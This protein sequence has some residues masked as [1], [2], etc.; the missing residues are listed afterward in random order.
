MVWW[1]SLFQPDNWRA[2]SYPIA[3]HMFLSLPPP[4]SP[5]L[6]SERALSVVKSCGNALQRLRLSMEESPR[7][8]GVE[9]LPLSV[10][11]FS[12]VVIFDEYGGRVEE[13]CGSAP[14]DA[15]K[16]IEEYRLSGFTVDID[17]Y[18]RGVSEEELLATVTRAVD[19]AEEL[20]ATGIRVLR[21]AHGY[22]VR[23]RL[24]SRLGF[25]ELWEARRKAGD[26]MQRLSIDIDYHE[27]S[28]DFLTN[29]LFNEKWWVE[30]GSWRHY[31]EEAVSPEAVRVAP[32]EVAFSDGAR[33]GVVPSISLSL[34]SATA[35]LRLTMIDGKPALVII[36]KREVVTPGF[37]SEIAQ[38][39]S[40]A[41]RELS[42]EARERVVEAYRRVAHPD[43]V[44]RLTRCLVIRTRDGYAVFAEPSL[45][46]HLVGRQGWIARKAEERLGA[47]LH[48]VS[49][50][51]PGA[52]QL[53]L[54]TLLRRALETETA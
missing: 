42:E 14:S 3:V 43:A 39:L 32:L 38:R 6:I 13:V 49:A 23:A 35:R 51:Q 17:T 33:L 19:V 45:V 16:A 18:K 28:L 20:G 7:Y 22:H 5:K 52:W 8:I 40:S 30:G 1:N 24:P 21:S 48:I 29:F 11:P 36:G 47:K 9:E 10:E 27:K 53:D 50:Q 4:P 37:A 12:L 44:F 46:P 2:Y 54:A 26:D 25:E 41:L 31:R 34:S 15:V